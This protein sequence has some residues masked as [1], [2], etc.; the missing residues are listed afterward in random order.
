MF[1]GAMNKLIALFTVVLLIAACSGKPTEAELLSNF[2]HHKEAMKML[3]SLYPKCETEGEPIVWLSST[4][5]KAAICHPLLLESNLRGI[6]QN[7]IGGFTL[8]YSG[9]SY[10]SEQ[11]NYFYSQKELEPLFSSVTEA[12]ESVNPYEQAYIKIEDGWYLVYACSCG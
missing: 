11:V 8:Y 9:N 3:L 1:L 5:E 6:S 10:N 2:Q 7:V 12:A 4:S